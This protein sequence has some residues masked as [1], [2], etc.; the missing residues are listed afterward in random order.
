MRRLPPTIVQATEMNN[1]SSHHDQDESQERHPVAV[2]QGPQGLMRKLHELLR[3]VLWRPL[4]KEGQTMSFK[5][6]SNLSSWALN[7][8]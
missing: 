3:A 5:R 1:L 4:E 2:W 8:L 7:I 6:L